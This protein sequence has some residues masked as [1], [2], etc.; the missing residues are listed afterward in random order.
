[1][2][3]FLAGLI[4]VVGCLILVACGQ[5]P[6]TQDGAR[7]PF[8]P[9]TERTSTKKAPVSLGVPADDGTLQFTV[10]DLKRS[11]T[12]GGTDYYSQLAAKGEYISVDVTVKNISSQDQTF[13]PSFQ[14]LFSAGKQYSADDLA[15][16]YA[17]ESTG[18]PISAGL[19]VDSVVVFDVPPGTV[20]DAIELHSGPTSSGVT[21]RLAG[22]PIG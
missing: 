16:S 17:D 2:H 3:V 15:T 9:N 22:A 1:M 13:Y 5:Q 6:S 11:R 4:A 10:T 8:L 21:V 20:P 12:V 7:S 14:R 19:A 18:N